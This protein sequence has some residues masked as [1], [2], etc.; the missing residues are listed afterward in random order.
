MRER[1]LRSLIEA[2]RWLLLVTLVY[3]PWAYGCTSPRAISLLSILVALAIGTWLLGCLVR[4][5]S[6]RVSRIALVA[7]LLLLCLGWW[8]ACNAHYRYDLQRVQFTPV[9]SLFAFAPG[10]FD[11][12]ASL[13]AMTPISGILGVMLF[14]SDFSR[15]P[16]WRRRLWWTIGLTGASVTFLGLFQRASGLSVMFPYSDQARAMFFGPFSYH[17][18]A[19]TFINL[20]LPAIAGLLFLSV[21]KAVD[22]VGRLIWVPSL[23]MALVAAGVCFSRTALVITAMISLAMWWWG[24]RHLPRTIGRWQ[25]WLYPA[26]VV[27]AVVGVTASIGWGPMLEK[28]R[29]LGSQLNAENPRLLVSSVAWRMA[30]DAGAFGFGE[31]TFALAFPYYMK[32]LGISIPGVWRHAQ[33]D[34]LQTVIEWGWLGAAGWFVLFAGAIVCAVRSLRSGMLDSV[35]RTLVFVSLVA[36][37]GI[38][39]HALVDYPLQIASL[40][41]YAATYLGM[42]WGSQRWDREADKAMVSMSDRVAARR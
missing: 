25:M 30:G 16:Q 19:G 35:D 20:V 39:L 7:V 17:G 2:P 6:P 14:V 18:N 10:G 9:P 26:L 38:A 12:A 15:R 40:Q 41:L 5:V 31:G 1:T 23:L 27:L 37:L 3:A 28:W 11:R 24:I 42:C 4:R 22:D 13:A 29:I 36:L 32:L 33:Q 34:Y 21:R 8:M